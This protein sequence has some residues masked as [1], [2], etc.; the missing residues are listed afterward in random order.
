MIY[1]KRRRK[2]N[3]VNQKTRKAIE[4]IMGKKLSKN[5]EIDDIKPIKKGA[6]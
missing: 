2:A 5:I 3:A 1:K 6:K 4:K